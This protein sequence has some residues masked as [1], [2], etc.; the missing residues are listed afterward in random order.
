MEMVLH[1][2]MKKNEMMVTF[3]MGM[4]AVR[5]V[6]KRNIMN[7]F[8]QIVINVGIQI[9]N[10]GSNAMMETQ[11]RVMDVIQNVKGKITLLVVEI[12]NQLA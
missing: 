9:E 10:Q 11:L 6:R 12:L 1:M 8:R 7:V 3:K 4:V 2:R 5:I